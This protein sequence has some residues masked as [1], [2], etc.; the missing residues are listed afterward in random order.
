MKRSHLGSPRPP[1]EV[2]APPPREILDPPL[3][4]VQSCA[5]VR[6]IFFCLNIYQLVFLCV[7]KNCSESLTLLEVLFQFTAYWCNFS[8]ALGCAELNVPAG[9]WVRMDDDTAHVTCNNTGQTFSLVCEG[10]KWKG[11]ISNC[12]KGRVFLDLR[13]VRVVM[14]KLSDKMFL[15]TFYYCVN[16][17]GFPKLNWTEKIGEFANCHAL[18]WPRVKAVRVNRQFTEVKQS[19]PWLIPW[20]VNIKDLCILYF[21]SLAVINRNIRQISHFFQSSWSFG[22]KLKWL[23]LTQQHFGLTWS[24][25]ANDLLIFTTKIMLWSFSSQNPLPFCGAVG[26]SMFSIYFKFY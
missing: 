21:F 1:Y 24:K 9:A 4:W 6:V 15:W 10:S 12:T 16:Q 19:K 3:Q 7:Y 17:I 18:A 20:W 22:K 26:K 25:Y 13:L 11:R 8:T 2:H 23:G 14:S 5:H